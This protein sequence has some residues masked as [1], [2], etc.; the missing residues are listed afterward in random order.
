MNIHDLH[1]WKVTPSEARGLQKHLAGCVRLAALAHMPQ[2]IAALDC[3][4]SS[5]QTQIAAVAVFMKMP[6]MEIIETAEAILEVTFPY[7]TG[8]LSFREAPA[9]LGAMRKLHDIPDVVLV[10]G[11]GIAHP[12]RLGL[13]SHLG[14]W[15]DCPT[16]GCAK[17]RLIGRYESIPAQ[18]GE[19]SPL[20]DKGVTIGSVLCTRDR[21]KPLFISPGHKITLAQ[22]I[23]IVLSCCTRYRLPEPARLAHQLVTQ[24][25]KRL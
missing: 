11:Q 8:L 4:F 14:L 12:R 20:K 24:L 2:T 18:K 16:I 23:E 17:S 6:K 10:D 21:V 22:S 13:A 3:A 25:R 15:L 7:V 5:D 1:S 9:C 19:H